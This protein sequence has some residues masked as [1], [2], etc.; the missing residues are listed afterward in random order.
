MIGWWKKIIGEERNPRK[1]LCHINSANME[2]KKLRVEII[3]RLEDLSRDLEES[4]KKYKEKPALKR[5]GAHTMGKTATDLYEIIAAQLSFKLLW[6]EEATR[7][8]HQAFSHILKNADMPEKPLD[9]IE[10]EVRAFLGL[11]D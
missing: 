7:V 3:S 6:N 2:L 10:Q 1:S 5:D 4:E 8:Y 9:I 11:V